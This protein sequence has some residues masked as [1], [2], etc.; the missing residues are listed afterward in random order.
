MSIV[1][2]MVSNKDIEGCLEPKQMHSIYIVPNKGIAG[3]HSD[4]KEYRW[5]TLYLDKIM[6]CVAFP[7]ITNLMSSIDMLTNE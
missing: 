7:G 4:Q 5:V 3:L 1:R 2:S 6:G